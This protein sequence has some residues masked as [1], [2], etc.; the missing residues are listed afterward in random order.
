MTSVPQEKV[1]DNSVKL[2]AEGF[3]FINHRVSRFQSNIF[4]TRLLLQNVVCLH[5]PEAAKVFY[6]PDRFV[7]KGAVPKWV[8]KTLLGENA[9]I[10]MD[11]DAH[12]HR[13]SM[14]MSFMSPDGLHTFNRLLQKH[15][16]AF[17]HKWEKQEEVVLFEEAQEL[18]CR[19]ACEWVGIP[20]REEEA[21]LRAQDCAAM[22]DAFGAVGLRH[23]RGRRARSRTENWIKNLVAQIRK[24]ELT[25]EE[26]KPAQAIAFHQDLEGNLLDDV[27]AAREIINLIR[28]TV[29]IAY[30]VAFGALALH[31]HPVARQKIADGEEGY[32]ELFVQ[33][34]RR[35]FPFAPFV[36]ARVKEDFSWG[37]HWFTKGTL[38]LLDVYGTLHDPKLW[39]HPEE[40]YPYRFK[41][42]QGS[43]FDLIPQGGGNHT[44]GHRCAGEWITIE[45]MKVSMI[46]MA[47]FM[48][49]EVP[50]QNLSYSLRRMPTYP[51]S[52]FI[53]RN[54]SSTN[55]ND[56]ASLSSLSQCPFLR[57]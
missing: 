49:Y 53:I 45:A 1:L 56:E 14:F 31:E 21:R 28:P 39:E 32:A 4:L 15:W 50:E 25:V 12:G 27:M 44:T 42:W 35:Y 52:K 30:Y 46:F 19:V 18:F 40:F 11:G 29:A 10:T 47:K 13:K 48:E 23:F 16:K 3:P 55:I 26:G 54:V 36:G 33:E 41:N 37:G 9:I 57:H 7:R 43:A 8:Q 5:G 2:L 22:V 20:L 34:V 6:D 17:I 24:G 51:K 38:V